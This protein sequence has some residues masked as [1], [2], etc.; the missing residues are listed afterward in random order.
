MTKK[1]IG[2]IG[3]GNMA[4]ALIQGLIADGTPATNILVAEPDTERREWLAAS[5]SVRTRDDNIEVASESSI[6]VLAVKPQALKAVC[7]LLGP[8][9]EQSRPLT[10]SIAAGIRHQTLKQWLNDSVMVVRAMPNTPAMIQ[11]G[12]TGLFSAD[13]LSETHRSDAEQIMRA[14]GL[15]QWVNNEAEMDAVTAISGSGPAYFFLFMEA[16]QAAGENLGLSPESARLLTLQTASGA[17][18]MALES[19]QELATLR[20]NVT[21]PGGTTERAV[22]SFEQNRIREIVQ[23]AATAAR[24]RSVELSQL[25]AE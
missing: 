9:M 6:L 8:A 21:S 14:V 13:E 25:L 22:N 24:D 17:A 15:T 12:A 18:R 3:G 11:L 4:T 20:A 5:F 1:T 23:E 10:I 7:E 19:D 16:L 2:F